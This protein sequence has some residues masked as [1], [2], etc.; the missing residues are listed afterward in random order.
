M[1]G[2]VRPN[3]GGYDPNPK[4]EGRNPCNGPYTPPSTSPDVFLYFTTRY[5][6]K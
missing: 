3:G 2:G 6:R 5:V 4:G 1:R